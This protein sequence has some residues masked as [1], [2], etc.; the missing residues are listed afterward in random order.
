MLRSRVLPKAAHARL[1]L[2]SHAPPSAQARHSR[3]GA[4]PMAC[5]L[6]PCALCPTLRAAGLAAC[7]GQAGDAMRAP[8]SGLP[9]GAGRRVIA[10]IA[11]RNIGVACAGRLKGGDPAAA[12]RA[13]ADR[14]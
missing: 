3:R 12:G 2:P 4:L 1:S 6:T 10:D 13:G 7:V 11:V 8:G 14:R 5:L 9:A